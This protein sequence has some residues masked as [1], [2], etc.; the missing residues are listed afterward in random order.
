MSESMWRKSSFSDAG[1]SDC[2]EVACVTDGM[3]VR[4]SKD[5]GPM[6]EIDQRALELRQL[7]C[8]RAAKPPHGRLSD[9]GRLRGQHGLRAPCHEPQLR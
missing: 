7:E 6:I 9:I 2:V 1:A 8:D 4:D 5:T 3:A